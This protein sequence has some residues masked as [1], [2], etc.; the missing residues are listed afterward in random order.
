[1]PKLHEYTDDYGMY[2]RS[3]IE[4]DFITLQLTPSASKFLRELG[5]HDDEKIS[6]GLIRPLWDNGYAYTEGNKSVPTDKSE[7]DINFD[8]APPLTDIEERRLKEFLQPSSKTDIEIPGDVLSALQKWISDNYSKNQ[9]RSLLEDA[10]NAEG[11]IRSIRR[12][13]G[14]PL[15]VNNVEISQGDP[16]YSLSLTGEQIRCIDL[17]WAQS[18]DEFIIVI[19]DKSQNV[20]SLRISNGRLRAWKHYEE[21]TNG[22]SHIRT[23]LTKLDAVVGLLNAIEEYEVRFDEWSLQE[24]S[25]I[26]VPEKLA[27]R[28]EQELRVLTS[29]NFDSPHQNRCG[30]VVTVNKHGYS[31]LKD[32]TGTQLPFDKQHELGESLEASEEVEFDIDEVG[33]IMK[34]VDVR[35]TEHDSGPDTNSALPD[36]IT[37]HV[38]EWADQP[39]RVLRH[40]AVLVGFDVEVATVQRSIKAFSQIDPVVQDFSLAPSGNLMY[41]LSFPDREGEWHCTHHIS[42]ADI[43]FEIVLKPM[44]GPNQATEIAGDRFVYWRLVPVRDER[45]ELQR[46]QFIRQQHEYLDFVLDIFRS[47]G[48]YSV[49]SNGD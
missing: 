48:W 4:G 7:V 13:D 32:E 49:Q 1:M 41:V 8:D 19:A 21:A 24:A 25:E 47:I 15:S 5:Y 18:S 28:I 3:R 34:A 39:E 16:G 17:R 29:S 2:V 27:A 30:E 33:H 23:L 43:D 35:P 14:Y 10:D 44:D 46:D 36:T 20:Q 9:A 31:V 26:E 11:C 40:L 42:T 37:D 38:Q 22:I 6:W 45:L 12:F